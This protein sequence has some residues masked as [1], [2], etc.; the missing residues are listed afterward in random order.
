MRVLFLAPKYMDLYKNV[1]LEM[2]YHGLDVTFIEDKP[3]RYNYRFRYKHSLKEKV[4]NLLYRILSTIKT[5]YKEYWDNQL[6]TLENLYFDV[7]FVINGFSYN[8]CL[9]ESLRSYNKKIKTRLYLWDNYYAY[10]FD[11]IISD[12]EKCYSL[13]Y[14]DSTTIKKIEFLPSFWVANSSLEDKH[15]KYDVFM[16]GTNHDDRFFIASNI[17]A[18]L[19]NNNRS[20]YIKLIDKNLP[21]DE[22]ISHSFY[23][24]KEYLELMQESKCVLDTERPSQTG[25]T[26]RLIWALS[27]GKKII[28]TNE[29][30]KKMPF[31]DSRQIEIIDRKNP[32][33]NIDFITEECNVNISEY[34]NDLRIDKWLDKIL[35]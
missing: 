23:P 31:Y 4:R 32:Q 3:L 9:L 13:D 11:Y 12:F 7:L 30:I 16:I 14:K 22:I 1:L 5:D 25:P 27:L 15:N 19:K 6:E 20:Y 2:K 17:I 33:I 18:Q 21:E 35:K 29:Y 28:S 34:I 24:T 10:N 26:V 8:R